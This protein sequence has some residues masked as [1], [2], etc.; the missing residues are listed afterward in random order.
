MELC[1]LRGSGGLELGVLT[2]GGTVTRLLAPDRNGQRAD[3]VLGFP[4][5]EDYLAQRTFFG[6][7]AGR[8]A[9]RNTGARFSLED[10]IYEL[11]PKILTGKSG[12]AYFPYAGLCLEG[13]GYPDGANTPGFGDIILR[14]GETHRQTTAY[15]FSCE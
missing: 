9:G 13:E 1:T 2:Y 8:V 3:V 6:C 5:L 4:C 15:I 14:P 7:T 11:A 10:K 12:R